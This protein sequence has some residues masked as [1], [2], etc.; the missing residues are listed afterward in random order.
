MAACYF[1]YMRDFYRAKVCLSSYDIVCYEDDFRPDERFLMERFITAS[2]SFKGVI[3][4]S[5]PEKR[6]QHPVFINT[7]CKK[8]AKP[9]TDIPLSMVS[10]DIECAMSGEL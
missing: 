7:K 1:T 8:S 9:L 4:P 3:L 10:L 2:I 6:P 5:L